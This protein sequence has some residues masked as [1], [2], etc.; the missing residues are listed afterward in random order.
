MRRDMSSSR[1]GREQRLTLGPSPADKGEM[2][3]AR[4]PRDERAFDARLRERGQAMVEFAIIAPL[5][6]ILVAGII[7]FGVVLNFWLD[8]QRIANQG[9]RWAVVDAYPG[10]P[11]TSPS[12]PS[13]SPT[14]QAYLASQPVSGGL[15]PCGV[16][17]SFPDPDGAGPGIGEPKSG[18][19]VKVRLEDTFTLVPI[20]GIG[21]LTL[22]ADAT[23]RQEW[24]ATQY[25]EGDNIICP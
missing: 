1:P 5:F 16:E 20:L 24:E 19:P 11:R 10:C 4:A 14:L 8:M 23:M 18:N 15:D 12:P 21:T 22:G 9:A 7:Q 2:A 13:C 17:I 3:S 6:I 25:E